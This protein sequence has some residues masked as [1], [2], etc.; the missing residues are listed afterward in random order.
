MRPT[1]C[2]RPLEKNDVPRVAELH[3]RVFVGSEASLAGTLTDH[4]TEIF[5][6]HPCQDD[7]LPSLV[8]EEPD[9][10]ITGC[11]GVIPRPMAMNGS[12]IRAAICHNFMVAPGAHSALAALH[13]LKTFWRGPQDL[14]VAEANQAARNIW[15]GAG[16]TTA[17]AYCFRWTRPLLPAGY[18]LSLLRAREL[19]APLALA[20]GP[21]CRLADA[22][23]TRVPA[24]RF[25]QL[26]PRG[27][28]EELTAHT[29]LAFLPTFVR[30]RT[31]HPE[32]DEASL[33][34]L[35]G[36]LGHTT[37]RGTLQKV[38]LRDEKGE[39]LGWYLYYSNPHGLG[40]VVQIGAHEHTVGTVLDH[41]FYHAWR[42]GTV[43]LS[44]Q[45]DPAYAQALAD[46]YCFFQPGASWIM[47]H[48]PRLEVLQPF[49][50]G[51][52]FFTRLE[53]ESW[54]I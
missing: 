46:R 33:D 53:G 5:Y 45:L 47:V 10:S 51:D 3:S 50:R 23:A 11:L 20:L 32:Y 2:V 27:V 30:K 8:Y 48:S 36:V 38:L 16:G 37:R 14:S 42:H 41:L 21:L 31:L 15:K 19:P 4:L 12:P 18:L 6:R 17:L 54:N 24:S 13:L 52:A 35:F 40:E 25:R 29:L 44:G 22:V 1:G 9:G 26:R 34:W 39:A 49:L 28:A 43:A 7:D